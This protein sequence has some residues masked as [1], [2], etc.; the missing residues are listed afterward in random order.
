MTARSQVRCVTPHSCHSQQKENEKNEACAESDS[1][2]KQRSPH[3]F[4][5]NKLMVE[6]EKHPRLRVALRDLVDFTWMDQHAALLQDIISLAAEWKKK[7][8]KENISVRRGRRNRREGSRGGRQ[9]EGRKQRWKTNTWNISITVWTHKLGQEH[10]SPAN[11][12][13]CPANWRWSPHFPRVSSAHWW[14]VP[15]LSS[16]PSPPWRVCSLDV[17]EVCAWAAPDKVRQTH[18]QTYTCWRC[19]ILLKKM[20]KA[21]RQTVVFKPTNH[22]MW[23]TQTSLHTQRHTHAHQQGSHSTAKGTCRSSARVWAGN[24]REKSRPFAAAA[25]MPKHDDQ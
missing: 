8:M 25:D 15:R 17:P 6:Q 14:A 10:A 23:K 21:K 2:I 12:W 13:C 22:T 1:L 16:P 24:L 4:A 3:S 11:Q 20:L 5:P 9:W 7:Q 19:I 18:I